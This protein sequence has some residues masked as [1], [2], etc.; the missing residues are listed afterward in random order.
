[1]NTSSNSPALLDARA[2]AD[3]LRISERAFYTLQKRPDFPAPVVLGPRC[4]RY[5]R[6]RLDAFIASLPTKTEVEEP[7][8]LKRGRERKATQLGA[9]HQNSS[10]DRALRATR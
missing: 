8:Q 1:M 3:Y 7:E 2:A 9:R 5:V 10:D 4:V 6:E